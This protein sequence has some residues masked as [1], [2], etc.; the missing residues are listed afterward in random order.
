MKFDLREKVFN[1]QFAE[2]V[3]KSG[4]TPPA[5]GLPLSKLC[6]QLLVGSEQAASA[7]AKVSRFKLLNKVMEADSK[8]GV[9]EMDLDEI[10]ILK[11]LVDARCP[12]LVH[13][14]VLA[15]LNNPIREQVVEPAK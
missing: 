12:V 2:V 3:K 9:I 7:E 13:G 11:G 5:D 1:H 15:I 6:Y 8:D 10:G 4:E 14:R